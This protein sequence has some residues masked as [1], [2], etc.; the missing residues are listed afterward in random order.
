MNTQLLLKKLELLDEADLSALYGELIEIC[1]GNPPADYPEVRRQISII[2]TTDST[3]GSIL[4]PLLGEAKNLLPAWIPGNTD[5]RLYLNTILSFQSDPDASKPTFYVEHPGQARQRVDEPRA[6]EHVRGASRNSPTRIH[7]V[8][9]LSN[10]P[11]G[12]TVVC[13]PPMTLNATILERVSKW[14]RD[15]FWVLACSHEASAIQVLSGFEDHPEIPT[16]LLVKTSPITTSLSGERPDSCRHIPFL[17]SSEEAVGLLHRQFSRV[18]QIS[19]PGK[20]ALIYAILRL[21]E[22]ARTVKDQEK[23]RKQSHTSLEHTFAKAALDWTLLFTNERREGIRDLQL[24]SVAYM[25]TKMKLLTRN[26]RQARVAIYAQTQLYPRVRNLIERTLL[27]LKVVAHHHEILA[28]GYDET[29]DHATKYD[30]AGHLRA[31]ILHALPSLGLMIPIFMINVSEAKGAIDHLHSN[32]SL[33]GQKASYGFFNVKARI[34]EVKAQLLEPITD[35]MDTF[36]EHLGNLVDVVVA[37]AA[38]M[39]LAGA[40][41]G[42]AARQAINKFAGSDLSYFEDFGGTFDPFVQKIISRNYRSYRKIVEAGN[43]V[44]ISEGPPSIASRQEPGEVHHIRV[45]DVKDLSEIE[46]M[47]AE[48]LGDTA[49]PILR[50]ASEF[51]SQGLE[52]AILS[53]TGTK[54]TSDGVLNLEAWERKLR[55]FLPESQRELLKVS[56]THGYKGKESDVVI[57]LGPEYYPSIHPDAVFNTIFGDTL[58]SNV[59]DEKRLFYVGVT[60]ARTKLFLLQEKPPANPFHCP[61]ATFLRRVTNKTAY[62]INQ[63]TARLVCGDRVIVRI[64]NTPK[65][66]FNSGTY[67][68]RDQLK[69]EGFKWPGE[70]STWSKFL[71]PGSISSPLECSQYLSRQPWFKEADGVEACFA[72]GDQQHRIQIDRG[73]PLAGRTSASANEIPSSLPPSAALPAIQPPIA[74]APK[75]TIPLYSKT[76][77]T[78]VAGMKY[79]GRMQKASGLSTGVPLQL[80]REPGN[81]HDRNAIRVTT[82]SNV[83]IGYLSRHVAAHLAGAMDTMGGVIPASVSSVWKQPRPHFLVSVQISF[84]LPAGVHI[85][86]EL[87]P[88][89]TEESPFATRP[90]RIRPLVPASKPLTAPDDPDPTDF[91]S[92]SLHPAPPPPATPTLPAALPRIDPNNAPTPQVGPVES[93]PVETQTPSPRVEIH[94]TQVAGVSQENGASEIRRLH[95]GDRI[96]LERLA[97]HPTDSNAILVK[98]VDART[99]GNIPSTLAARVAA[100]IDELGGQ[101]PAIVSAIAL[102]GTNRKDLELFIEFELPGRVLAVISPAPPVQVIPPAPTTGS[103]I[104]PSFFTRLS[105]TQQSELADLHDDRLRHLIAE[106]Y[107]S[108]ACGWPTIGY[109]AIDATGRCT[110][111][112]LEIAWPDNNIGIATPANDVGSFNASGWKILPTATVS[113]IDLRNRFEAGNGQDTPT[114]MVGANDPTSTENETRFQHGQFFDDEPDDDI[115]F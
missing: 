32:P 59:A 60:R 94:H 81:T 35:R 103:A 78:N 30:N 12:W 61:P 48:E 27:D 86:L 109:E 97:D 98:S 54:G 96:T 29:S 104:D 65:C 63:I 56:T 72:W 53:R 16:P 99:L 84:G 6:I 46:E 1:T 71:D 11:A 50:L 110:G 115:P 39:A 7:I 89:A 73:I 51:T 102:G 15:S 18:E 90:T 83:H 100:H 42:L 36:N 41:T 38:G 88:T 52:V 79:E 107:L 28:G 23:V 33:P 13:H 64:S 43:L 26:S 25:M 82:V 24:E 69:R 62:D 114:E 87:N 2:E 70:G 19:K 80:V 101:V 10:L 4:Q 8:A 66:P 49:V 112:M 40:A 5:E 85:P 58:E 47:V 74:I 17:Q 21:N 76:F 93:K 75:V 106:L 22:D 67:S 113:A 44:M 92:I 3:R 37:S 34:D 45:E 105:P 91:N 31:G 14:E 77:E 9:A 20:Q 57:M 55:Q 95:V 108:G 68:I 111:S